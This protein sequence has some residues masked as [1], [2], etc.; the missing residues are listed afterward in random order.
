MTR[1]VVI[2]SSV[3]NGK[4]VERGQSWCDLIER[5][6]PQCAFR[7]LCVNGTTVDGAIGRFEGV[8]HEADVVILSFSVANEGMWV[9]WLGRERYMTI[10]TR[11]V[12]STVAAH[13][14]ILRHDKRCLVVGVYPNGLYHGEQCAVLNT[15]DE[16]LSDALGVDYITVLQ[17]LGGCRWNDRYKR[18]LDPF[19]PNASA[20]RVMAE[21]VSERLSRV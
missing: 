2:G 4:S 14:H 6:N 21:H 11:F 18:L 13:R 17:P 7:Q 15:I 3:A 10:A 16:R 1:V 5:S 12:Q 9:P 19:H 20:H 8:K